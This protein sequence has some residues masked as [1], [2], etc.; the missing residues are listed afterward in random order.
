MWI[1]QFEQLLGMLL[2]WKTNLLGGILT[3]LKFGDYAYMGIDTPK[4]ELIKIWHEALLYIEKALNDPQ[5]YEAY[6]DETKL[7][8]LTETVATITASGKVAA[9]VLSTS[10]NFTSITI[11][12]LKKVTQT[13]YSLRFIDENSYNKKAKFD[14]QI[15]SNQTSPFFV[16]TKISKEYN[17]DNYVK[18]KSNLDAF[19]AALL[20]VSSPSAMNPI[21]I[22]SAT[23]Y[24]KTH[25]LNAIG[26]A[27]QERYPGRKVLYTNTDQFI[28]EF[29]KYA[30]GNSDAD[31]FK[32]Y[33]K[34][35]DIL[36]IDDIQFL[37]GKN[38]TSAFFFNIFN[39]MISEKKQI[40]ITSDRSP[41]EL[42]GLEDRLVSRFS[43]GLSIMI[44][45]P[46]PDTMMDILKLKIVSLG[47]DLKM[48]D[49]S[50]LQYLVDHNPANI[51]SM[52]GD[53]KKILF[54]STT[55]QNTGKID[56]NFCR[57]AFGDRKGR[58]GGEKD[59]V[60][61][62]KI[63]NAVCNYYNVTENQVKSKVRTLQITMARQISMYLC[64]S[65]LDMSF[66]DIGKEFGRDHSTVMTAVKK[67]SGQTKTD[68]SLQAS[69]SEI[70]K[71][72]TT[73]NV[74]NNA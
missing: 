58:G 22:Y 33:F 46:Q 18:G 44:K 41:A 9:R 51:R 1:T 70:S 32:Q 14:S 12:A 43:G 21:F 50:S 73:K 29:V 61:P 36:L 37:K 25:L 47:L 59:P 26:N 72:V 3:S 74:V 64:R 60:S 10:S 54:L 66:K 67:I 15:V 13:E 53:L 52:E 65:L 4:E 11:D 16:G 62:G 48:F 71:R 6:F 42:D 34:S 40:V 19:R 7:I 24:G 23:G 28:D 35:I 55:H 5:V 49:D 2:M 30:T 20:A 17:F 45:K 57:E 68:R 69:L 8:A 27:Y 56:L 39:S 31:S 63:I 38:A